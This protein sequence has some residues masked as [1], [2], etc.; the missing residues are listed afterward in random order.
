MAKSTSQVRRHKRKRK[1]E[2]EKPMLFSSGNYMF[3]L[4]GIMMVVTGFLA[5]YIESQ[6]KGFISLYVSPIVIIAGF[7]VVAVSILK[8]SEEQAE[9]TS[10]STSE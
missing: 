1:G 5:M 9:P 2:P 10:S 6:E 8:D 4:I 7:I 3:M